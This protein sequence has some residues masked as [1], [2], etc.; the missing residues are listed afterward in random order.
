MIS[1]WRAALEEFQQGRDFVLAT[2]L[3]VRGSSP[4]HVGAR[5][6][7]RRNGSIVGTIGGGLFEAEVRQ[8]AAS[9]LESGTSHR[10]LF[11]FT[12]KDSHSSQMICGG[13]AEVLVEFVSAKD[14]IL[15]EIISRVLALNE[16][17][18]IG[19]LFTH[20]SMPRGGQIAGS[21]DHLL[22]E[23]NGGKI[24]RLPRE[25][26]ALK[27]MPDRR[28]LKPAQILETQTLEYPVLLEWLRPR[29]TVYIFGAGH[30]GVCVAHLASYVN[31]RVVV[32]DDRPDF[33]TPERI[34]NAEHLVAL[35][36]FDEAFK[37]FVID[38]ESYIVI[39]TRGHS[40][41]RIV[42]EQSLKTNAVY[43]GMIGSRR[44]N[45]IVFERLLSDGFTREDLERV[46]APIGLPIG[47]ETPEEIGISI[48][49]EMI[50]IRNRKDQLKTLGA[51]PT[52]HT[53]ERLCIPEDR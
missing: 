39:V 21:V 6:L 15:G 30:V 44:K 23:E 40:H 3:D 36:S 32:L 5:F 45:R 48:L 19:Y 35:K 46:H 26:E 47:G 28:L 7:V 18:S 38:E 11:S 13:E 14:K 27:S 37:D 12:G 42:L 24:G 52:D 2:I 50:Q 16:N 17:R 34:P 53:G 9:A 41:D 49:A 25:E 22:V 43:I 33:M 29:G 8:F 31:F 20:V 10:A 1:V 4:R 51:A